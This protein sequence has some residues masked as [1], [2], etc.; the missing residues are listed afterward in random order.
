[1]QK[2]A[3][4]AAAACL[5][6]GCV[7]STPIHTA[8]GGQGHA[9]SCSGAGLYGTYVASWNQCLERAGEICGARGYDIL[10][11]SEETGVLGGSSYNQYGGGASVSTSKNRSMV[12]R[13]KS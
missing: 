12:V 3:I 13:C 2:I 8:D 11:K 10:T 9:I 5:L 7:S 4:A 6:A 1:M